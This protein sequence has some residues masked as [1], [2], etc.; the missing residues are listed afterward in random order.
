MSGVIH[1]IPTGAEVEM[2]RPPWA[3]KGHLTGQRRRR[4]GSFR[5]GFLNVNSIRARIGVLR[6]YLAEHPSHNVIGLAK[7]WLGPVVDDSL[8]QIEGYTLLRQDRNIHGGGVTLYVRNIYKITKLVTSYTTQG[9]GTP[10]TPEYLFCSVQHGS[11]PPI[12]VGVIYRPPRIQMQKSTELFDVL[13]SLIVE[14]SHKI[15]MGDMNADL[16][17]LRDDAKT[18]KRL[19][20][21][22]SLRL[23]PPFLTRKM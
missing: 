17:A 16:L 15:I 23:V 14:F 20:D 4:G 12:L 18:I 7:T 3:G 1:K 19:A 10:E 6:S 11:S 2:S 9:Q 22:L 8:L 13:R 21:E 5:A